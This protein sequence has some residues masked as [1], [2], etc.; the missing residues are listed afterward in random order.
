MYF[1]QWNLGFFINFHN[2]LLLGGKLLIDLTK[3]TLVGYSLHILFLI[4]RYIRK[5]KMVTRK[6]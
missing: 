4:R 5:G 2:C 3:C 1:T 6:T